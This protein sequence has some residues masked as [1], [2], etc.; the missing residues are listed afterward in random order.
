MVKKYSDLYLQARRALLP[1]EGE[2]A[3]MAARE[4]LAFAS[5][6]SVKAVLAD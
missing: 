6:K 3:S 4:R 5:G 1:S 2:N